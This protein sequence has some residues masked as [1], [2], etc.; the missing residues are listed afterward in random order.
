MSTYEYHTILAFLSLGYLTEDDILKFHP[1]A[2]LKTKKTEKLHLGWQLQGK[3]KSSLTRAK[4]TDYLAWHISTLNSLGVVGCFLWD[5]SRQGAKTKD[6]FSWD[7]MEEL[8]PCYTVYIW[9]L[10]DTGGVIWEEGILIEEMPPQD[11]HVD[12]YVWQ[13]SWLMIGVRVPSPLRAVPPL[14]KFNNPGETSQ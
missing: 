4:N 11:W 8:L 7:K 12:K 14:G 1:L 5:F 10:F 2:L 13:F 6:G 9:C 3:Q